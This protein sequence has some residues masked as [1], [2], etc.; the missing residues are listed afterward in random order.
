MQMLWKK[1]KKK[2]SECGLGITVDSR[3][4]RLVREK[5]GKTPQSV[6]KTWTSREWFWT[7]IHAYAT[8]CQNHGIC[9][10]SPT[11]VGNATQYNWNFASSLSAIMI[12][13]RRRPINLTLPK[14]TKNVDTP[15]RQCLSG[16]NKKKVRSLGKKTA[17]R[18]GALCGVRVPPKASDLSAR[19]STADAYIIAFRRF[20]PH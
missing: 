5:F 15:N 11:V 14:R 6:I 19:L 20:P 18:I 4:G 8:R 7:C 12:N 2:R 9:A 3:C 10:R 13:N 17:R 16:G 1:K